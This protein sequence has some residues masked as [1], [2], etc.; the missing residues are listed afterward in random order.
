MEDFTVNRAEKIMSALLQ[1]QAGVP[2]Y[3]ILLKCGITED[4]L[5]TWHSL[6]QNMNMDQLR[7]VC[8]MEAENAALQRLVDSLA[9]DDD[10]KVNE[11][12]LGTTPH[13]VLSA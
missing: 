5:L 2:I 12:V 8:L 9:K 7:R 13:T 11:G 4:I 3:T 6:Y 1:Y 10:C